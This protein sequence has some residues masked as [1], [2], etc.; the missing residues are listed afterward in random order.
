MRH[1]TLLALVAG[2]LALCSSTLMGQT[3]TGS[4]SGVVQDESGAMIPGAKVTVTHV[5]QGIS[6]V[7][8]TNSAGRYQVP[9]LLPGNYEVQAQVEGFQ[10]EIRKGIQLTVGLDAVINLPL[11]VGQVAQTTVV[12]AQ[13]PL[14]ETVSGTVSGLVDDRAIRD[15]PLNGRSFEQLISLQSST[16]TFRNR[17][18]GPA[19]GRSAAFGMSGGRAGANVFLMDGTEVVGSSYTSV[20]PGGALGK[21]MGVEAIQEF[22]V[23][24]SNYSAAYGKRGGGVINMATR[25]G[26]NQ[27]HGSAYEFLRNDN[28]DARNF[29][30]PTSQ[31][32]EFKRNQF[33][34]A[35]GGPI[36]KDRTFFFGNYEGLRES[37]GLTNSAIV[38]DDN[39][40]QGLL[41][42][43][44]SPGQFLNVGVAPSVRP[45]L[46][47]FPPVNGRVFG[48]GTGESRSSPAQISTQ[49][50]FLVRVDHKLSDKD[51]FFV[52]YNFADANLVQPNP[53]PN[54]AA[55]SP[56]RD[57]VLTLQETRAYAPLLNV[58]RVGFNRSVLVTDQLPTIPLDPSLVFIPGARAIGQ[59]QFGGGGSGA[60]PLTNAGTAGSSD[61]YAFTNQFE[62]GDQVHY[63][64][65]AHS[66]Q[67][68]AKYQ[69]VQHNDSN[70]SSKRGEFIFPGLA[71]FLAGRPTIFRG[72]DPNGGADSTKAWRQHY[73]ATFLQD[74]LKVRRNL[75]LNLGVRW[76][77]MTSPTEAGGNRIS[78]FRP[79]PELVNGLRVLRTEP[80]LG[81]PLFHT[82]FDTVAPRMGFAWDTFGNGKMAVRGGFGIF[83]DQIEKSAVSILS[84]S[85]PFFSLVQV[86]NPGFPLGFS[87][88]PG[89]AGVPAPQGVDVNA[90]VGTS[91]TYNLGIEREITP[92]TLFKI[93]YVGS[94]AYHL[95]RAADFNTT[96][97]QILPGGEYFFPAGAPRKNPRLGSSRFKATDANSLYNSLQLDFVQRP[98]RGLRYKLSYTFAKTID[99]AS[100]DQNPEA[101]NTTSATQNP[102]DL[103]ADRSLSAYDLRHNFVANFTFD[104]PGQ[105]WS[106][107][108]GRLVGGW[109]VGSIVTL[110]TGFPFIALTGFNR[111]RDGNSASVADRPS[112]APGAS[113][114]PVLGGPDRYFDRT[115]FVLPP[116]GFYGNLGR[117]TIIGPGFA[118]VDFTLVKIIQMAER[119]KLD[120]R[121]EFFNLLNRTN[122]GLPSNNIFQSTGAY[123]G[124]AGRISST[125][126]TSRQIQFG[127]KLIF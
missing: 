48:D 97:P 126:S 83:Y 103:G 33:G 80:F 62:A 127:L 95:F 116:A 31:P 113:H 39:A 12:T 101:Q 64:R 60:T 17:S 47:I 13:A 66:F 55:T 84:T 24:T 104:L 72:P 94:H 68:G 79:Q 54:F 90:Q 44:Q 16:P 105:N 111:S 70:P 86:A 109:Q 73:F 115:A 23:L 36:R 56:T 85:A 74:D 75:T 92:N 93:G 102:D 71:D 38:P 35:L 21:N 40:R 91:L 10:T 43:P 108:A 1:R 32:P 51:S 124:A 52:R 110:S 19:T 99:D 63:Y 87:G 41:R 26:T 117:N 42:D 29:F 30:D 8:P 28:L 114:S 122:F 15:L 50:F 57:Q 89:I 81:A 27:L 119:L 4:I 125:S 6:R 53:N 59:I 78:N 37:L 22:S 88:P 18:A 5:D 65:G 61:R 45:F 82:N 96:M 20:V 9:G 118:N 58:A 77:F 76:E 25:S 46:A 123:L 3:P 67:F 98:S 106:G 14:V 11:R 2:S 49:D 107:V 112:L 121:A 69:R 34:G 120:F 7:V 100:S